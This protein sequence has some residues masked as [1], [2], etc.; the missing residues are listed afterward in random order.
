MPFCTLPHSPS[1]GNCNLL[2]IEMDSR[3]QRPHRKT[4]QWQLAQ[5]QRQQSPPLRLSVASSQPDTKSKP[6]E[7]LQTQDWVSS[8]RLF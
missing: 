1:Q 7:D 4:L 6:Q 5:E 2:Y 8:R 3:Q